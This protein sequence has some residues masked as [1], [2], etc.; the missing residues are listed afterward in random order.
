MPSGHSMG[1]AVML[2][3]GQPV[4]LMPIRGLGSVQLADTLISPGATRAAMDEVNDHVLNLMH[5]VTAQ[6]RVI[7]ASA[8]GSRFFTDWMTFFATWGA[9]YGAR[10]GGSWGPS[11]LTALG[12]RDYLDGTLVNQLRRYAAQ[13]NALEDRFTSVTG[14]NPTYNPNPAAEDK[15]LGLPPAAWVGI[16]A[17]VVSLGFLAWIASSYAKVAAPARGYGRSR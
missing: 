14:Q 10:V 9:W 15:W 7:Q 11:E 3:S 4:V 6:Q 13:Y 12:T 17:G 8:E 5:D 1:A 2:E 16:G